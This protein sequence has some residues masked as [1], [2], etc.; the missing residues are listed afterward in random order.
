[1]HR[2]YDS[3]NIPI[4]LLR[5]FVAISELGTLTKAADALKLTQPAVSAQVKR[6]QQIVGTSLLEKSSVGLRPTEQGEIVVRYARRLLALNDQILMHAGARAARTA[7]RIGISPIFAA[8]RLAAVFRELGEFGSP[9]DFQIEC[10]R[11]SDLAQRFENGHLDIAVLP[12]INAPKLPAL[13]SWI[14]RMVWVCAPGVMV[15]PGKPIPLVCWQGSASHD[16][17]I[18]AFNRAQQPYSPAFVTDDWTTAATA[19]SAG[20]GYMVLP[21]SVAHESCRVV[22]EHYLP[23]VPDL[24]CGIFANEDTESRFAQVVRA[25]Y[26][27]L[28]PDP[29]LKQVP[30]VPPRRGAAAGTQAAAGAR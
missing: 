24:A 28:R 16:L 18:E 12:S 10:A 1:M 29:G 6:L 22:R 5:S 30:P 21:E 20:L 19:L 4:E 2:R 14:D 26:R 15:S 9:S 7:T 3:A 13:A 11:S 27:V 25:L 8:S 17:T 23:P